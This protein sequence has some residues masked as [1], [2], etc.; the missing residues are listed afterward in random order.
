MLVYR[1]FSQTAHSA[2]VLTIGNFD[3]VH[4]GH[5]ALLARL[6]ATAAQ[7]GLPAA[8]LTFE[9]HPREFFAPESAPPRLSTLREKLELL[10][11]DGV[12]IA[13]VC[14]FNA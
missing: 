2:T 10:A 4:L 12:E 11:D 13:Y 6:T 5:R 1:G 8:V 9:P 14:H 3:G 7:V